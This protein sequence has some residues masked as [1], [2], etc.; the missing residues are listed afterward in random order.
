MKDSLINQN[1]VTEW[2]E[3]D[4]PIQEYLNRSKK[5][6]PALENLQTET[7]LWLKIMKKSIWRPNRLY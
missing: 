6:T 7:S 4:H 2:Y 5:P 1:E 3:N